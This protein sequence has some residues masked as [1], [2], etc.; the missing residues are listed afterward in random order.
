MAKGL[1]MVLTGNGKGKST[2]AMGMALRAMGHGIRVCVIQFVKG[3]RPGGEREAAKRFSDL[4][5]F[6]VTGRG[7]T[8]ASD[9]LQK[10]AHAAREGWALACAALSD[11][12][13]GLVVLDELTY[14]IRYGFLT[15]AAVLTA[16]GQRPPGQHAVVTGR[17]ASAGLLAA[18]DL[19]TEMQAVKHPLAAGVEAQPGVEF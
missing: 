8:W 14:P 5:V 17:G 1:L 9:D 15:E 3:P 11:G 4:M 7:F 19:V 2:A 13:Y 16:L 18:A 10:D 12:G 6:Q